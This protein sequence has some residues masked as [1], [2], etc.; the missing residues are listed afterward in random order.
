MRSLR[1]FQWCGYYQGPLY[2]QVTLVMTDE[3]LVKGTKVTSRIV[4][5]QHSWTV[6]LLNLCL[7]SKTLEQD[8]A[9]VLLHGS[10]ADSRQALTKR[11]FWLNKIKW[12]VNMCLKSAGNLAQIFIIVLLNGSLTYSEL[13]FN[14]QSNQKVVVLYSWR[15]FHKKLSFKLFKC[16]LF[17]DSR[18]CQSRYMSIQIM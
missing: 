14:S 2:Y 6:C 4:V 8:S 5:F 1:Y 3:F 11:V 16:P 9:I 15:S 17:T 18:V 7:E 13:V 10:F 12:L